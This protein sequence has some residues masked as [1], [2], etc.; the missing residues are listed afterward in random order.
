MVCYSRVHRGQLYATILFASSV[1]MTA[2]M[3]I[4]RHDCFSERQRKVMR[5]AVTST[6]AAQRS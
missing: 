6:H 2:V 1:T 5:I 3:D 4:I